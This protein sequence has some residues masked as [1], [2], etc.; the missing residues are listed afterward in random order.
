[1]VKKGV[2]EEIFS[3]AMFSRQSKL[4]IVCFRDF[5]KIRKMDLPKF[6]KESDNF[7][8]IPPLEL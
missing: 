3:K 8:K 4:Y 5:E 6:I 7:Q 2:V 1:M